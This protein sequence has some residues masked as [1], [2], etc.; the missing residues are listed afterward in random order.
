ML[1]GVSYFLPFHTFILSTLHLFTLHF[2]PRFP[3]EEGTRVRLK[4][5]LIQPNNTYDNECQT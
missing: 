1:S 3:F 5:T 2:T 4:I